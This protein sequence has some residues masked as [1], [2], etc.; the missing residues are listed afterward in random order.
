MCGEKYY[1]TEND[2]NKRK[3][4]AKNKKTVPQGKIMVKKLHGP[5]PRAN[6]TDPV[7]AAC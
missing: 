4:E 3:K 5:S 7:T 1:E 6:Y 2:L